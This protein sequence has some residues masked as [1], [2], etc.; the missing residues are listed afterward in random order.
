MIFTANEMNYRL[1]NLNVEQ[2]KLSYQLST[3]KKI[4]DGSEDTEVFG[5]ELYVE[6]KLSVYGEVESQL[7]KTVAQNRAADTALVSMKKLF[8]KVKAELIKANTSAISDK[9]RDII[10]TQLEGIKGNLFDLV[11]TRIEGDYVFSGE[12]T[13]TQAFVKDDEGKI[14]YQGSIRDRKVLV[15]E[16]SYRKRSITGVDLMMYPTSTATKGETLTFKED[17]RIFDQNGEEWKLNQAKDKLVR[18]DYKGR[19]TT[20]T[21]T[22]QDD[23]KTPA[24]YS[25][26]IEDKKENNG[27]KFEAKKNIFDILDSAINALKKVDEDGNP[28]SSE[29]SR[30]RIG[31]VQTKVDESISSVNT[32]HAKLNVRNRVFNV[33]KE[34]V[35]SRL[36][37]FK[38]LSL[39]VSGANFGELAIRAKALEVT[40]TAIYST[41]N[42]TNQ[43]S[44]V[45][46]VK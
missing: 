32:A 11:N 37:Q 45:N 16:G 26:N 24:T 42:K 43:L 5:Q 6:N 40:Y 14:T 18:Y 21:L 3:R 25:V 38:A 39:D 29:E 17:E 36:F 22:V 19:E 12:A 20:D 13:K 15:E 7:N 27:A 10:G 28:I 31:E 8:D 46:Y 44:L 1:D 4:D 41:I 2:R 34:G 30:K 35:S 33:A 23:G 9:E